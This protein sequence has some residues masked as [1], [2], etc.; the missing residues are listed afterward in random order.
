MVLR[1]RLDLSNVL[2]SQR[3]LRVVPSTYRLHNYEKSIGKQ[4]D[5]KKKENHMKMMTMFNGK[6]ENE[7]V[8]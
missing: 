1:L 6:T 3:L 8:T 4:Q 5:M 2:I 7:T